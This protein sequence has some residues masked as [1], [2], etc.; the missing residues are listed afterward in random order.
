MKTIDVG[1]LVPA[2]VTWNQLYS[3]LYADRI[4]GARKVGA[5]SF[6]PADSART[7]VRQARKVGK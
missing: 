4:P 5:H 2:G 1:G 6:I 7:F 3:R